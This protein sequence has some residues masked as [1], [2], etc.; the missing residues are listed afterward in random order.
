MPLLERLK[1]SSP[2][3]EALGRVWNSSEFPPQL[4]GLNSTRAVGLLGKEDPGMAVRLIAG[5]LSTREAIW[6][7]ALCQA[8]LLKVNTQAG[9][10]EAL[11]LIVA[12]VIHPDA[13]T[14]ESLG[15][16]DESADANPIHLLT[17]A[18]RLT[19]DNLSPAKDHPVSA[20]SGLANKLAGL[21]I[22]T[23]AS[24]WPG[25]N[26]KACLDHFVQLGLDV[27]EGEHSWDLK[28]TKNAKEVRLATEAKDTH[29]PQAPA[30]RKLK[31]GLRP[32]NQKPAQRGSGNIWENW[33]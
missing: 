18:V 6:W 13:K 28:E 10:R 27:T 3:S 30:G 26:R 9:P 24:R 25:K 4:S 31:P 7:A 33:E 19:E 2:S 20:P 17:L 12:W 29:D 8:Q 11:D 22:L 15:K 14:G 1:P 16:Q 32:S 5:W 23:A 21:S